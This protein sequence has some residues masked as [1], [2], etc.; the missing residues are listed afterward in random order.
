MN[1]VPHNLDLLCYFMGLPERVFAWTKTT[2]HE[3]E[4]ED[5]AQAMLAWPDGAMGSVHASTAETGL[6][7]RFEILGTGGSIRMSGSELTFERFETDM[8]EHIAHGTNM[9]R[10]PETLPQEVEMG[11]GS[12]DHLA[13]YRNLHA[14]ILEGKPVIADGVSSRIGLEVANAMI[15]SSHTGQEV[16]LPLDRQKYAAL[17]ERLQSG[18]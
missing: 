15:Y 17:L 14:A 7:S 4:T 11:S 1:Q 12:G 2:L 9:Y 18:E 16:S 6:P 8:L 10:G 5:T 13:I 3:I